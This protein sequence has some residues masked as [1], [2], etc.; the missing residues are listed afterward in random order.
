L[1]KLQ[2]LKKEEKKDYLVNHHWNHKTQLHVAGWLCSFPD[3][4]NF[5]QAAC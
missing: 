4:N 5:V 2:N 3:H 1:K